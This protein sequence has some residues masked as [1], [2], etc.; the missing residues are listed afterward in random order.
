MQTTLPFKSILES[1]AAIPLLLISFAAIY[2]FGY[3]YHL[4]ALW[5]LPS[6]SVQ[7]L[8]YSILSTILLFLAGCALT[9][10]YIHIQT[11]F[12]YTVVLTIFFFGF[13]VF[14]GILYVNENLYLILKLAPLLAGC[15]YYIYLHYSLFS[16]ELERAVFFPIFIL[17]S[18]TLSFMMFVNGM[19]DAK[20]E[21][22]QEKLSV[23]IFEEQ[24]KYPN[25]GTDWRLLE[26]I[27]DKFV[28]INLSRGSETKAY[29]IKVVE[30]KTINSIH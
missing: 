27:G 14:L 2:R 15:F 9:Y 19:N 28:L 20:K 29:P 22:L 3:F 25:Q 26:N 18:L 7:S 23:V 1:Y 21:K 13:F 6:L 24:P 11:Y 30:Y 5:I 10:I 17:L 8:L 16:N 12:G 4:D